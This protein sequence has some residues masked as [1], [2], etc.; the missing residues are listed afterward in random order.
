ME[1]EIAVV[2]HW[3]GHISVAVLD[4]KGSV[5]VGDKIRVKHGETEF[6]DEI[7]SMQINHKEVSSAE[8]GDE[9]AVKLSGKAKEGSKIFKI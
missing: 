8:K 6:E 3:Y 5:S 7:K 2:T 1:K 9:V 4:L